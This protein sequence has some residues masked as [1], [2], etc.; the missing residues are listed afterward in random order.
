MR[1]AKTRLAEGVKTLGVSFDV[2]KGLDYLAFLTKWNKSFN[3]TAITDEQEMV[4]KH[5][6]DCLAIV[7]YI[8]G[9][10]ILDVGSG[11]GLPGLVI[12]LSL[13]EVQVTLLDCSLKRVR[14][15]EQ[16]ALHL[17]L[18]NVCPIHTRIEKYQPEKPFD[19]IT[20][21]AFTEIGQF[22]ALTQHL[23]SRDGVILA[24]KG[25]LD[26]DE[27]NA[28][29]AVPFEEIQLTVPFLQGQRHLIRIR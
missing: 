3:L 4:V 9:R 17:K 1:T 14:F 27:R 2:D 26:D 20:S 29:H 10:H 15:L 8:E 11:A 25:K 13:P 16:A 18:S 6:L 12:A 22:V 19:V 21:R 24:M 28:L 5:L 23:K 7:P